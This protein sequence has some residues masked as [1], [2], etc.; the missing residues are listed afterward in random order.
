MHFKLISLLMTAI[1]YLHANQVFAEA[2]QLTAQALFAAGKASPQGELRDYLKPG[3]VYHF[4]IFGGAKVNVKYVGAV[5]LGWDFAYSEHA[6]KN[7]LE[8]HYRRFSWDW[9]HLPLGFK[10]F[11]VKPGLSWVLTNVKIPEL[12][13]DESSIRPEIM[14]ETG[15]R[16]GLGSNFVLTGGGRVERTWLDQEKTSAGRELAITGTYGS[17]FTGFILHI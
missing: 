17:W 2:P 11:Y 9:F 4:S 5:G 8:G 14:F 15:M 1:F 3:N 7:D 16:V 6:F 13:I 10:F 12:D